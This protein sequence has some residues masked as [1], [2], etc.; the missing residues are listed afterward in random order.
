MTIP[1]IRGFLFIYS[2]QKSES[3]KHP[4]E[5]EYHTHTHS[6]THHNASTRGS[7]EMKFTIDIPELGRCG[8][9]WAEK[10]DKDIMLVF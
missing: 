8:A 4:R 3:K 9:F 10:R 7:E 6:L 1:T 2:V 5:E